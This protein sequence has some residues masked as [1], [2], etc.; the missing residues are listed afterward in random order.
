[1]TYG[2]LIFHLNISKI[3]IN[4]TLGSLEKELIADLVQEK[5][6]NPFVIPESNEAKT[7][8]TVSKGHRSQMERFTD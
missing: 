3:K 1:M 8:K 4:L 5:C 2:V 7:I 6:M